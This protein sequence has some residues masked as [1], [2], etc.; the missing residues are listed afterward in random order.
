MSAQRKQ[1][2]AYSKIFDNKK[3]WAFYIDYYRSKKGVLALS[4]LITLVQASLFVPLAMLMRKILNEYIPNSDQPNMIKAG[5]SQRLDKIFSAVIGWVRRRGDV[6]VVP[7]SLIL[8]PMR[9]CVLGELEG[10]GGCDDD[11]G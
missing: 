4:I 3:A 10:G 1:R 9:V 7:G 8:F 5:R 6:V 11:F 2:T